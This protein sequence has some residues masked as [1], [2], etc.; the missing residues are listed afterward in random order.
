[1]KYIEKTEK[2]WAWKELK[3]AVRSSSVIG[4]LRM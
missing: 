1:M 3:N 2:S 4:K